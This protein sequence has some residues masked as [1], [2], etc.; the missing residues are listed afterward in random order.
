MSLTQ[1]DFSK[2]PSST[3][4]KVI[5]ALD[6]FSKS[7]LQNPNKSLAE[8][9]SKIFNYAHENYAM[10]NQENR[11]YLKNAIIALCLDFIGQKDLINSI[12]K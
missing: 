3:K 8:S 1:E 12:D 2:T 4:K 10:L 11:E 5:I 6:G 9:G 7:Y